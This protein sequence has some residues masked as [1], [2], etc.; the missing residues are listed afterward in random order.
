MK[1]IHPE[2]TIGA[3]SLTVSNLE[4]SLAYYRE[5]IGLQ[6]L[7][8]QAGR[9]ELGVGGQP[10]LVLTEN[11][12]AQ[13][14]GQPATGLYHFALLLPSRRD[15]AIALR[16]LAEKG[17]PLGASDHLVSEA[18]YLNDP[19]ENGIEIYADRPREQWPIHQGR[20]AMATNRL[21][22]NSV[23]AEIQEGDKW[24]GL[25]AGTGMGHIHLR[26]ADVGTAKHFY[27]EVVGFDHMVD[28]GDKA[29]FYSA[30]GYHHHLGMNSWESTGAS[31]RPADTPG[32][33]YFEI[34]VPAAGRQAVLD[35]LAAH[36]VAVAQNGDRAIFT[37]P[38]AIEVHLI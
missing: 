14:A 11:R 29:T 10:L 15:L 32:L 36:G 20:L 1:K 23:L 12:Q 33:N 38:F 27:G 26:V 6:I 22:L 37:D 24:Q 35:R 9:A 4:R 8:Q 3:V 17:E 25:P 31:P 28:Y 7:S 30:G 19:D 5:I 21:N 2:T 13:P 16:H 34:V 18:L